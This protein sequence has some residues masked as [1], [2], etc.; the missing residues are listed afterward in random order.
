M[1][2]IGYGYLRVGWGME[3]LA[4]PLSQILNPDKIFPLFFMID[5]QGMGYYFVEFCALYG[6][7][8]VLALLG[9]WIHPK[10]CRALVIFHNND[11][12]LGNWETSS[13]GWTTCMSTS[14]FPTQGGCPNHIWLQ[15]LQASSSLLLCQLGNRRGGCSFD[16]GSFTRSPDFY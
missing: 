12:H 10:R 4:V 2:W 15:F 7:G 11:W 13:M 16:F 6:Y 3:H 1:N 8:D 14:S 5:F 9:R